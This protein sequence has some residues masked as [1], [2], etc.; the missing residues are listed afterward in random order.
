MTMKQVQRRE[1]EQKCQ[2]QCF[3]YTRCIALFRLNTYLI[4]W[5]RHLLKMFFWQNFQIWR[6]TLLF[7]FRRTQCNDQRDQERTSNGH[8]C[9]QSF[10]F[11]YPSS[12]KKRRTFVTP[13]FP[14]TLL[15]IR[16]ICSKN[17]KSDEGANVVCKFANREKSLKQLVTLFEFVG[18]L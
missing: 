14:M 10:L 5:K 3:P 18:K 15:L 7:F 13:P 2:L 8:G 16:R 6:R 9:R 1:D 12:G 11:G 4:D 17:Q